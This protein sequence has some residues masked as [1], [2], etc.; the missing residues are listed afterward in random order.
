MQS[1]IRSPSEPAVLPDN[2]ALSITLPP[3]Q[4]TILGVIEQVY[5]GRQ[6]ESEW[7]KYKL[8]C[9][10]YRELFDHIKKEKPSLYGFIEDKL[11]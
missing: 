9:Q 2:N 6:L 7:D 10:D 11:R 5:H 4:Q 1:H 3:S 8:R